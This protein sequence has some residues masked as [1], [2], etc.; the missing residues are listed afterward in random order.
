MIYFI[1]QLTHKGAGLSNR[2]LRILSSLK[3]ETHFQD[4]LKTLLLP[5]V[6]GTEN[7]DIVREVSCIF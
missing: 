5:R 4:V 3:D 1:L 6:V 2:E 7:H